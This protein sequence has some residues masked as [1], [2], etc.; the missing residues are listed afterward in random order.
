LVEPLDS[1]RITASLPKAVRAWLKSLEIFAEIDS[2]SLHLARAAQSG[3]IDGHVVV[4]DFQTAGRGRR[5]RTWTANAGANV[6]V[7]IG[8]VLDVPVARVGAL[9]LVVGLAVADA[10]DCAGV[11]GVGLKWPNDVLLRGGKLGGILVELMASTAPVSVIIGIGLNVALDAATRA[12]IATAV[13]AITDDG[14]RVDRNALI[15]SVIARV[16][17]FTQAFENTG[18]GPFRTLWESMNVHA[19]CDV[20][21]LT[22]TSRIGGRVLGVTDAGELRLE[23][24]DGEMTFSAGEVSLRTGADVRT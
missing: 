19:G 1:D 17:E 10:L 5:G 12:H 14:T 13:A 18:F 16:H 9:S 7:S 21:V 6:A 4:A 20:D 22:G 11:R 8:H 3:S 24:A 15:G 23:T 2:T